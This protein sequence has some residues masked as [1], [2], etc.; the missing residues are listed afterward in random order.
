[1]SMNIAI[2]GPAGAGKSTIAKRLAKKLGFI[3]V[4][5]GAMYRAMAY[6]FL[7]H[8]IDAKDESAIAA[9][10]PDVDVTITYENGEQQVLLNGENV[11]GVIRNEE[12]GNMA[13]ST[14][15][16]PVVREKLVELQRQLAKS[17][18]VIMD[19]R[20]IGTCVL[21]DAQVKIY[22]TASSATR[23]KRRFDEL[24]EKG[25]SCDLAEIEKDIIDRD[26]RD[27][28][29]ETSPLCQAEDAVLVDSS[30]MNIDEVVDAIYQVY[31][32]AEKEV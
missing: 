5:T 32:K 2:D 31:L 14:S 3:Y 23:A 4:D 28:H 19:G 29:R 12:V 15:V 7:Q 16:Y 6:Y 26:Y 11:N 27:M 17:A 10:C 22:L 18:D 9:A 30:E 13:S 25:V 20:D 24:T 8:D 1:M 21:P